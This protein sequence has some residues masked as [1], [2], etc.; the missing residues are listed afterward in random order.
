MLQ[1]RCEQSR[2]MLERGGSTGSGNRM[3]MAAVE[4]T[5]VFRCNGLEAGRAYPGDSLMMIRVIAVV[6]VAILCSNTA[7]VTVAGKPSAALKKSIDVAFVD[8]PLKDCMAFL[9]SLCDVP[10]K[11]GEGVKADTPVSF[12]ANKATLKTVLTKMLKSHK[13][14]YSVDRADTTITVLPAK[15]RRRVD[16]RTTGDNR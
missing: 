3:P 1:K 2:G 6:S 9:S 13:L 12:R 11:L 4:S 16:L 8:S 15:R 10:I 5:T 14:R 7:S